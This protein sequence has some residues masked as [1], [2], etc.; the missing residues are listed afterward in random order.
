MR[1]EGG[2]GRLK[3]GTGSAEAAL[4]ISRFKVTL[5]GLCVSVV[6][7][8]TVCASWER[9]KVHGMIEY[10]FSWNHTQRNKTLGSFYKF[11]LS[12]N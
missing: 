10:V 8:K 12:T 2:R 5:K 3:G 4:F 9:L 11:S 7:S 6:Q 1:G